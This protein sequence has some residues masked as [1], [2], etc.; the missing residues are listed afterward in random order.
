[1]HFNLFSMGAIEIRGMTAGTVDMRGRKRV[2]EVFMCVCV[3]VFVCVVDINPLANC[4]G[5]IFGS[6]E[7]KSI[8]PAFSSL[9]SVF[10]LLFVFSRSSKRTLEPFTPNTTPVRECVFLD[11]YV[12]SH[13]SVSVSLYPCIQCNGRDLFTSNS[14][15]SDPGQRRTTHTHA[16][17]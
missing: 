2:R 16:H 1:M 14:L 4:I 5:C 7:P 13:S 17:K 12:C 11:T 15:R 3:C 9:F 10:Y 8:P 6:S